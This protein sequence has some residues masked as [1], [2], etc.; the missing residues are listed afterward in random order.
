MPLLYILF[1]LLMD[2]HRF[3]GLP[4]Q[5]PYISWL[6]AFVLPLLLTAFLFSGPLLHYVLE[7][8]SLKQCVQ[9]SA[10]SLCLR[11]YRLGH[12]RNLVVVR[13]F[14]FPNLYGITAMVTLLMHCRVL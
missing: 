10:T 9:T 4:M 11:Q 5:A 6:L 2:T 1:I 3:L 8:Q 13:L 12:I 7:F 14:H